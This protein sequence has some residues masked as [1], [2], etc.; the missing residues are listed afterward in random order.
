[1]IVSPDWRTTFDKVGIFHLSG[2]LSDHIPIQLNLFADHRT[3]R[4]PF[5]FCEMRTK[6]ETCEKVIEDAWTVADSSERASSVRFKLHSTALALKNWN[7]DV[8]GF[9]QTRITGLENE[10]QWIQGLAPP[11]ENLSEERKC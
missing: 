2:A 11:V 7:R 9:C 10:L 3:Q 1:M 6:D 5:H 8:L 4:R